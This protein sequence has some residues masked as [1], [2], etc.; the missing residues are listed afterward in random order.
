MHSFTKHTALTVLSFLISLTVFAQQEGDTTPVYLGNH[1]DDVE[2]VAA[3]P[4]NTY[5]AS[6]SWDKK[7]SIFLNDSTFTLIQQLEGHRA[8]VS[9]LAFSRDGKKLLSGGRDYKVILWTMNETTGLFEKTLEVSNVHTAG[10]NKVLYG[11]GMRTIYSAG[12]DGRIMIYDLVKKTSKIIENKIPVRGIALSTNK[13]FIFCA[14]ESTVVKQYDGLG[15]KIKDLEG[16]TDYVN[17]IAYS[18]DNKYLVTGSNDKTAIVWD[19]LTGKVKHVLKGHD[20]KIVS[21]DISA[22][23]KYAVTGSIDGKVIIWNLETGELIKKCD[24]NGDKVRGVAFSADEKCIIGGIQFNADN[25]PKYGPVVWTSGV[26]R[27]VPGYP[28]RPGGAP[29]PVKGATGSNNTRVAAQQSPP[30][31]SAQQKPQQK[32]TSDTN[33]KVIEKTDEVEVYIEDDKEH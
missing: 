8:A 10:I 14:D 19:V 24:A 11:P 21:V 31:K 12:D 30:N 3:S 5:Y 2:C 7:I 22:D 15:N 29:A 32:A 26:K 33:K 20:W 23:S 18:N 28:G 13:R 9:S 17:A 4:D 27:V 6:G 25:S 16:H 1:S